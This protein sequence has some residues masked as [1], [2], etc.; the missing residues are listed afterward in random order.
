MKCL[1]NDREEHPPSRYLLVPEYLI[2]A[3]CSYV[4]G[5][6][7]EKFPQI[8]LIGVT[9]SYNSARCHRLRPSF[10]N[11]IA[12]ARKTEILLYRHLRTITL[13]FTEGHTIFYRAF[14]CV[15]SLAFLGC[16]GVMGEEERQLLGFPM[17]PRL[18]DVL[19]FLED[20]KS[21]IYIYTRVILS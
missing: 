19:T 18:T 9:A 10:K 14:A 21:L 11:M 1:R 4:S 6:W 8:D 16:M 13:S 2:D 7:T 17:K 12:A 20:F 3:I 5:I 15:C